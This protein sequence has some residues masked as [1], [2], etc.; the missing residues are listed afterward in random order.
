MA[1]ATS[2]LAWADFKKEVGFFLSFG[3]TIAN[4]S[5]TQV[6][7][8]EGI[9]QT[10]L[11][12]VLYPSA[13]QGVVGYEWSFL[14][15]TTTLAIEAD[16]GDYDLPDDFGRMVGE[17]HYAPDEHQASI[18][19]VPLAMLLDMRSAS[20]RNAYPNF[21]ATRFKDTDGASGQR[22]E[23]LFYPEPDA[24][25]TLYYSYDSYQGELSD[26]YPYPPGG[27]QMSELYKESCLAAAELRNGDEI[28]LHTQTFERLLID[29]VARD[30]KRGAQNFG[31]MGQPAGSG[32]EGFRRGAA[33]YDGAYSVTYKGAQI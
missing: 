9:V 12:R 8:I 23:V 5:A 7:T 10:G 3:T 21:F 17:F 19:E 25:Y 30:R 15:P 29:A 22:Q 26:T 28:G 6:V 18:R 1:E 16:D 33:L 4:W 2:T 13:I 24:D 31:R 11:R 32:V 27:M 14:R 20:D